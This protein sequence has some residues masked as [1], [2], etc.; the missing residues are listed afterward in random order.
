[1]QSPVMAEAAKMVPRACSGAAACKQTIWQ[2][3]PMKRSKMMSWCSGGTRHFPARDDSH[4]EGAFAVSRAWLLPAR[5]V[6]LSSAYAAKP[7]SAWQNR[8]PH[9]LEGLA[10]RRPGWLGSLP[11]TGMCQ[12]SPPLGML[13][14]C[15]AAMICRC[16]YS[17]AL[18][19]QACCVWSHVAQPLNSAHLCVTPGALQTVQSRV[20]RLRL[21]TCSQ[22]CDQLHARHSTIKLLKDSSPAA[23]QSHL[24]SWSCMRRSRASGRTSASCVYLEAW[25]QKAA[26]GAGG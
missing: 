2:T 20:H 1:M 25:K 5:H 9:D 19:D 17:L 18:T 16:R 12:T 4:N 3:V 11:A 26:T 10:L 8:S 14:C 24:R 7:R 6:Q 22:A 13:A 23:L 21:C 15:P